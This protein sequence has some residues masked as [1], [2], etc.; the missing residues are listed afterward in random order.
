M[1][2]TLNGHLSEYTTMLTFIF[3]ISKWALVIAAILY[4]A[5]MGSL[6]FKRKIWKVSLN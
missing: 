1:L 5:V 4:V 2:L 3:S 6:L